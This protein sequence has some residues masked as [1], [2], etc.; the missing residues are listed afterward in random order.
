MDNDLKK[1]CKKD[2]IKCKDFGIIK[3]SS[4][5]KNELIDL[6]ENNLNKNTQNLK[7]LIK[8]SG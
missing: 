7:P 2:L 4:K 3:Y 8:W 6:I 5:N 1:L